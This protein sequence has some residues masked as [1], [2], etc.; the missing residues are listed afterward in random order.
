M[1]L[2]EIDEKLAR[3]GHWVFSSQE[4]RRALGVTPS[5]AK[6]LLI[7]YVKKGH[8]LKLK[9]NRGLYA[10][11][12]RSPHPWLVANRLLRPSYVSLETALAHYGHIPESVH[13]V[14]SVTP[15]TSK[16]YESLG[17]HFTYQKVKESA[18]TGYRPYSVENQTV[19]IA[20]P[21]KAAADCLYFVHLGRK[22]IN[23]RF[24]WTGLDRRKVLRY[25]DL[26][27]RK[28]LREWAG[29]VIP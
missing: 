22:S 24:R 14:T 20:E 9:E 8:V 2:N 25:L 10:L 15:K 6:Q 26:F 7:R 11:K 17:L 18:F 23:D 29:H 13:A 3:Q 5:S 21:E 4:F 1:K 16:T 19:W 27:E 12:N 28:R